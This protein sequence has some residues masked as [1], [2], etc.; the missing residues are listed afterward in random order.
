MRW[1]W[2]LKD[3]GYRRAWACSHFVCGGPLFSRVVGRHWQVHGQG[4]VC[5]CAVCVSSREHAGRGAWEGGQAEIPLSC[6]YL[7]R[8]LTLFEVLGKQR[9][10][11]QK[12]LGI[13]AATGRQAT[14][15]IN[16]TSV[17]NRGEE[18]QERGARDRRR[19]RQKDGGRGQRMTPRKCI[20]PPASPPS[21]DQQ[22]METKTEK[23]EVCRPKHG[24][25][26]EPGT[27]ESPKSSGLYL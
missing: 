3:L 22:D 21:P 27:W 8:C 14:R 2:H 25:N 18:E 23:A 5:A 1:V 10:A 4:K 16:T 13:D 9:W 6:E 17:S 11:K 7:A 15:K 12:P 20:I 19:E 24:P 26:P